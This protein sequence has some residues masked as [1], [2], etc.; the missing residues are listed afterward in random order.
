MEAGS[1]ETASST[2]LIAQAPSRVA[3][4]EANCLGKDPI[5]GRFAAMI[6][7]SSAFII[8]DFPAFNG[9]QLVLYKTNREGRE[10]I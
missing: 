6:T 5:G 9:N 2:A 4:R 10:G 7:I 3:D 8:R 1:F